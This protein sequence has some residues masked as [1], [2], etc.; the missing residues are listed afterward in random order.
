VLQS[1]TGASVTDAKTL[2]QTEICTYVLAFTDTKAASD[3]ATSQAAVK[4]LIIRKLVDKSKWQDMKSIV[5][6]WT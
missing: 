1:N 5:R 6:Q 4:Q 3:L 2:Q